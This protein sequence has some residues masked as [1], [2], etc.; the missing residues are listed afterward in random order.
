M[1]FDLETEDCVCDRCGKLATINYQL[2]WH[3]YFIVRNKERADEVVDFNEDLAYRQEPSYDEDDN[4]FL[5]DECDE[6]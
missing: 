4:E 3:R 5:C 6:G 2:V 1:G